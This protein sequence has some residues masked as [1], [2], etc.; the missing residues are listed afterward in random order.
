MKSQQRIMI[1]VSYYDSTLHLEPCELNSRMTSLISELKRSYDYILLIC[2]ECHPFIYETVQDSQV[3]K[4]TGM[5]CC[6]LLLGHEQYKL[7]RKRGAFFFL[8]E[9][10]ER[11]QEIFSMKLGLNSVNAKSLMQDM[12]KQIVYLDTGLRPVPVSVLADIE[13]YTGL[14]AEVIQVS[15][16]YLCNSINN[17]AERICHA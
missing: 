3:E 13:T 7:L 17:A 6:E 11:W 5:N 1:P 16:D 12:H 9:W 2:G 10:T 8:P 15:L 14:E 4:L